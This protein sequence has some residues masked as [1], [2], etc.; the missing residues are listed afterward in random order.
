VANAGDSPIPPP[1]MNLPNG[2]ALEP[3]GPPV[4]VQTVNHSTNTT[5]NKTIQNYQTVNGTDA[6]G[7][8]GV[9]A[10]G[11]PDYKPPGPDGP[12]DGKSEDGSASGGEDCDNAPIVSDPMLGMIAT[13]AWATRCAVKAG[14]SAKVTGDVGDCKTEF[15]VEG[16]HAAAQQ[17]RAMR[18]AICGAEERAETARSEREED[19]A[20]LDAAADDLTAEFGENVFGE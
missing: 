1:N 11:T 9:A 16:D 8:D 5:I 13:Q 6:G 19:A 20:S 4:N 10:P 15:T 12:D 14:N 7:K 2:D 17:L 3:K 18:A